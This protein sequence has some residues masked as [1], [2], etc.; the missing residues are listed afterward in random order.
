M[1]ETVSFHFSRMSC[2]C[3]HTVQSLFICFIPLG[4]STEVSCM[5]FHDLLAPLLPAL[6]GVGAPQFMYPTPKEG[7]LS[8]PIFG[9][10]E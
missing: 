2:S 9:N 4:I 8:C 1:Y 5:R 10:F 6:N 7:Y 3:N